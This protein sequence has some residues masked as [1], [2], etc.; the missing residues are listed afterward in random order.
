MLSVKSR[1]NFESVDFRMSAYYRGNTIT[2]SILVKYL[3]GIVEIN[4]VKITTQK[5][6]D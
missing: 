5:Y 2:N 6:L 1:F 4:L 3:F